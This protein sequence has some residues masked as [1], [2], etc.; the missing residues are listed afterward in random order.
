[1]EEG[2]IKEHQ[3]IQRE[4]EQQQ[5]QQ[6]ERAINHPSLRRSYNPWHLLGASKNASNKIPQE[7][8]VI[9]FGYQYLDL[10]NCLL[11]LLPNINALLIYV[12]P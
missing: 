8:Q 2:R 6:E 10:S 7:S 4:E 9:V 1:M 5:I 11:V 3:Q 12:K